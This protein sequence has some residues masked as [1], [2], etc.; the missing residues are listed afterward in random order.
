MR[1][2]SPFIILA[3]AAGLLGGCQEASV[4]DI[5]GACDAFERPEQPVL[6]KRKIDQ[7]WIDRAVETGVTVCGWPRP[8]AEAIV[9][10][11]VR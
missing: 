7:R 6:G 1:S 8:K 4:A 3:C 5:K 11:A 9:A 2:M 10:R